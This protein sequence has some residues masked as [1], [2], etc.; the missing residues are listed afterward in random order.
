MKCTLRNNIIYVRSEGYY[1]SK[2]VQA[3]FQDLTLSECAD[4]CTSK[5]QHALQGVNCTSFE[6]DAIQMRCLLKE[7]N[8]SIMDDSM[9]PLK[10]VHN[11]AL[12]QQL[13][14][15]EEQACPAP[16][17]FDR[18]PGHVLMGIAKE[19][20]QVGSVEECLS[21]CL[22]A[23]REIKIDCRSAMY[24]YDTGECILN[25][26]NRVTSADMITND[27]LDMRVDYFENSCFDMQC[28]TDFTLHWIKVGR[29]IMSDKFDIVIKQATKEECFNYCLKNKIDDQ[30]FSCKL[31]AYS[32]SKMTCHLTSKSSLTYS[33]TPNDNDNPE[34]YEYYEKICL[35]GSMLCQD[36]SFEYVSN[37]AL[38][39]IGNKVVT[40]S[41]TSC[42]EICLRSGKQC[43]SVMFFHDK[44]ECIL[45]K[46]TQYSSAAQFQHF[47]EVDYFDNVCDYRIAVNMSLR[48]KMTEMLIPTMHKQLNDIKHLRL[49]GTR[50][51]SFTDNLDFPDINKH[52]NFDLEAIHGRLEAECGAAGI[53]ISVLFSKPTV[54]A[55]FLKDHF[56]TCRYEFINTINATMEIALSTLRQ[57]NPPCP[58]YETNPS[59]WSFIVVVQKNGLGIPGL[60]TDEDRVFNITCDYSNDQNT[61]DSTQDKILLQEASQ[62]WLS[63]PVSNDYVQ[64]TVLRDDQPVS[65]AVMGEELE[66]RWTVVEDHIGNVGLFV[67][68]CIAERL[69]GTPPA[70]IP[71]TLIAN[72]QVL[73]ILYYYFVIILYFDQCIDSKV[74]RLLMQHP[75]AQFDGGLRTKIK[76]F[77]FD[78]SRRVRILCSVDICVEEC[79]PVA[80]DNEVNGSLTNSDRKKRETL[81]SLAQQANISAQRI[82]RELITGIFTIVEKNAD[83]RANE[84]VTRIDEQSLNQ[85]I[86]PLQFPENSHLCVPS[87]AFGILIVFTIILLTV[88]IFMLCKYTRLR[89]QEESVCADSERSD[90]IISAPQR[91]YFGHKEC[92]CPAE[93]RT[94][95]SRMTRQKYLK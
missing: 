90:S 86:V 15:P 35:K 44:D 50:L 34:N 47:P 37:H 88:Q 63:I 16:Y 5:V 57:D 38:L 85:N 82:K 11:I 83:I 79:L 40:K 31:Y 92:C 26:E 7:S 13:C 56:A 77:R 91:V 32:E 45:G 2:R 55:I 70:P 24:Y 66:M 61:S 64:L 48:N 52:E 73:L 62:D 20:L 76:V 94:I 75:I 69:D 30:T 27:T 23:K 53:S 51:L 39:D 8:G 59:T 10:T 12:F 71:L 18:L 33:A 72:G 9:L 6:Y 93:P 68:R 95:L 1:S 3:E 42:L 87:F 78:G 89:T 60:M 80:C 29:F 14:L 84:N 67:N 28:S 21:M 49:Y 46:T 58:G 22:T 43:S 74:S 4:Q 19:V 54:G 41:L 81:I 17:T 36:S 25:D 65:T